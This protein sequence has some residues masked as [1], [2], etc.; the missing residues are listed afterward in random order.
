M[1]LIMAGI[2]KTPPTHQLSILFCLL[3]IYFE[4]LISISFILSLSLSQD[5]I[6]VYIFY[7]PEHVESEINLNLWD[8]ACQGKLFISALGKPRLED[9]IEFH[10]SLVHVPSLRTASSTQ[11]KYI[12]WKK[13]LLNYEIFSIICD[14]KKIIINV[15]EFRISSNV[16][17]RHLEVYPWGKFLRIFSKGRRHSWICN[18]VYHSL[19]VQE[20]KKK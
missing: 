11:G 16:D 13:K 12:E 18:R 20:E 5:W 3:K 17:M 9:F 7:T 15:T 4:Y 14:D 2:W 10:S 8:R 19:E 6:S 1:K